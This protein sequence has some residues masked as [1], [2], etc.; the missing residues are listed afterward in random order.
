MLFAIIGISSACSCINLENTEAKLE[1]AQYVFTGEVINVEVSGQQYNEM[2]EITVKIINTFKP[3]QFPEPVNMKIYA[4]K[5]TGANCGYN[6]QNGKE[7]LIYAYL[8]ENK[9]TTNSCM[10]NSL[11]IKSQEEIKELNKL[12][13]STNNNPPVVEPI[14]SNI[15]TKFFNWIRN[16][17]S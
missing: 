13:N 11:L 7:Y 2:Q 10:G 16:L 9:F 6:F 1:N 8:E 17:F 12:T 5:D 4:T 3:S 14:K 15:F